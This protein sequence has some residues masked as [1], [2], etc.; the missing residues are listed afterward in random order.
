MRYIAALLA[1]GILLLTLKTAS[2][3]N[4]GVQRPSDQP[5]E[6]TPRQA[7]I[8][9]QLGALMAARREAA[10]DRQAARVMSL[11]NA[12]TYGTAA[13]VDQPGIAPDVAA[14]VKQSLERQRDSLGLRSPN[15]RTLVFASPADSTA[16]LSRAPVEITHV[17]TAYPA[18]STCVTLIQLQRT[19]SDQLDVISTASLYGVCAF[20]GEYGR[21]GAPIAAW[22][23]TLR[24]SYASFPSWHTASDRAARSLVTEQYVVNDLTNASGTQPPVSVSAS[25]FAADDGFKASRLNLSGRG[26]A[27]LMGNDE[28]CEM[29]LGLRADP[30]ARERR[31]VSSFGEGRPKTWVQ[32]TLGGA[33]GLRL[34]TH[35]RRFFSDM[36][37]DF[38]PERFAAFW[39]SDSA[40]AAAFLAAFGV[41]LPAYTRAWMARRYD[42]TPGGPRITLLAAFGGLAVGLGCVAA[43]A[44]RTA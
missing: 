21:P 23:D 44:R 4:W 13:Y 42:S 20:F 10:H 41:P 16:R 3:A 24:Y 5:S 37:H 6:V 9:R 34:G 33:Y 1:T 38:G 40:P 32:S 19:A 36:V 35:E 43:A 14:F 15:V 26:A 7:M 31:N 18:N 29:L 30:L 2:I 25:H 11:M 12:G 27:C 39:R 22:L 28:S 8:A 17:V